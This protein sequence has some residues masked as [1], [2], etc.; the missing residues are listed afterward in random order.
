MYYLNLAN[1][2]IKIAAEA[3]IDNDANRAQ[4]ATVKGLKGFV[5]QKKSF[6][7]TIIV[8]EAMVAR[9]PHIIQQIFSGNASTVEDLLEDTAE[10]LGY[11]LSAANVT[12]LFNFAT[13]RQYGRTLSKDFE[14]N[15]A[16]HGTG[17]NRWLEGRYGANSNPLT[18]RPFTFE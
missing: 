4:V 15:E 13:Q 11:Y 7:E 12:E 14:Y 2:F 3:M 16:T 9:V 10:S 8:D 17:Y 1:A 6:I 18:T 5:D